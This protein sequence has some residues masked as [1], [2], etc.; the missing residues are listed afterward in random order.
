MDTILLI[1]NMLALLFVY[2]LFKDRP[3][4]NYD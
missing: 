3:E 1:A 4:D 2:W